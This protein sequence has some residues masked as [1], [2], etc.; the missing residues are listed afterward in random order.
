MTTRRMSVRRSL[1][2]SAAILAGL[3]APATAQFIP[4]GESIQG[5]YP[6]KAYSPYAQR[7]FPSRVFWGDTH[8]HTGLSMDAGLF[9]N[10][11]DTETMLRFARGEEVMASS[12]QPVRLSRPLDWIVTTEH[13]DGMGMITDLAAGAPNIMA[14][15]QGARWSEALQQGGEASAQAALDLITN[16]SQGTMD[17]KLIADYSPGSPIY[18]SVW[19]KIVDT[20][21]EYNDPGTFTAFHGYEWTSL[22]RGNNMHRNVIF[23]DDAD[24]A[25]QMEPMVTQPPVGSTDPMDLYTWLEEYESKTGGDVFALSHNGN[26]SNGIMFPTD[27]RYDGS[28]VDEAYV[29]ARARW[30][31]LYEITQ[32]KG[33]GEAHPTLSPEDPFADYETWD[34][35]NL[36]LTEAKTPEMLKGEYAR[37][38]LKQGMALEKALGVN[39]YKFGFSGATDSHTSLATADSDNY[40]GKATNAEPS[41]TR[42]EHPFT[43]TDQGEFPGWSLV[44][45]GYT[46]IWAKENTRESLWDAMVRRETYATTGPRMMV[47]FFGGWEFDDNDLRSRAPAFAGYDKGVPMGADLRAAPEG[48]TAPNFM[49]YAL[50][51]PIGANLDRVQI[52]K[53]W[54]DADGRLHEKVYDVAW[55]GDRE[56]DA[57]GMV[58]EVGNTVDVEAA[59]YT[60]TIGAS[61]LAAIWTDPEFDPAQQAFYYARILEIPTPRWVLYDKLRLGAEIP[62]DAVLVGQERAY[63]SPIWYSPAG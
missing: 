14:S 33:D 62:E 63:T 25:L 45:S 41:P 32:I 53:G 13:S 11:T 52:V 21:E 6:G 54:M 49:V 39:P 1:V 35:G 42:A 56:P 40:F 10:T 37:E 61:E 17:P 55:S 16:F 7:A 4:S 28:P 18:A 44:A 51:D 58:P 50:R 23:R 34:A 31:P 5:L 29:R 38:A 26:L 59:N 36:D 22:I 19:K 15:E 12:G 3:G 2:I 20:V 9:G 47:R 57:N 43:K 8:I 24:R 46:G 48:A 27:T 60:N 30:E